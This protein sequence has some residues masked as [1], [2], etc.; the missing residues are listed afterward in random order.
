MS[1]PPDLERFPR[2]GVT[3]DLAILTVVGASDTKPDLRLL[4][5]DRSEPIGRALPGGFIRER[6]TVAQTV[7]DVLQRK[8]GISLSTTVEPRL[9]RI[10]DDPDRDERTWAISVAHSVSMR[11]AVLNGARG[12]LVHV[13][14]EGRLDGEEPL[15]FDHEQIVSTAIESL[16]E[17]YEFRYR[18]VDVHPDPDGF[19]PPPFTLHQLRKVHEA[20][21][22]AELHKDN[23]NRRMKPFLEPLT[24][25]GEPVLSDGLRGRPAALY[26]PADQ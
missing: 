24:R 4:V 10:F 13:T 12:D 14:S 7:G 23:F 3:V 5:Q 15:L 8:V 19:L 25:K 20:V 11:E 16:R 2:P 18:Y 21:V 1:N 9:L 26:R 17:R 6:W 22:G